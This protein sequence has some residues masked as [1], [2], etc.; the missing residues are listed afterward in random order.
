LS[1]LNSAIMPL[2]LRGNASIVPG[3]LDYCRIRWQGNQMKSGAAQAA[4]NSIKAIARTRSMPRSHNHPGINGA[5]PPAVLVSS[6]AWALIP[7]HSFC[8]LRLDKVPAP[9]A[10]LLVSTPPWNPV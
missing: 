8:L 6:L 2:D 4:N 7:L 10:E 5:N 3:H 9:R 1:G